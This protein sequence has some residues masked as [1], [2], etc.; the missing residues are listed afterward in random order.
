MIYAYQIYETILDLARKDLRGRSF[1]V[2]EYN[3]TAR[4][5]NELVFAKYYAE[6]EES[7]ENS[8]VMSGF[9]VLNEA[10]AIGL[11]GIGTLP[12]RY[13]HMCGMPHYTDIDG[14]IRRLDLVSTLEHAKRETDY[15]TKATLTHPTFMF[16]T[17]SATGAMTI[18]VTPITGINPINIDY[19]RTPTVPFLDYY[20][21]DL[22]AEYTW[23]R[24]GATVAMPLNH[25]APPI[26][27]NEV[28]VR[29]LTTG[30]ANV[31]SYTKNWEWS[32]EDLP[33]ITQLF[34]QQLGIQLP[35]PELYEGGTLQ[36]QRT[37]AQ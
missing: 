18:Y 5:V 34:L 27:V 21:N 30:A 2:E 9:K 14:V 13:Y 8:E 4:V 12:A 25:T 6:F 29:L 16:G 1:S 11:G 7:S 32:D 22:T 36:E 15:L 28:V 20:V 10:V 3:H 24:E 31:I 35:S 23:L 17:A 26:T 19:I 33:L 37:D